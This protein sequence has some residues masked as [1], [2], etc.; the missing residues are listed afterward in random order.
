MKEPASGFVIIIS[1]PE[2]FSVNIIV[3]QK[4]FNRIPGKKQ[5]PQTLLIFAFIY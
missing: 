1:I 2:E 5:L 3:Y 4:N